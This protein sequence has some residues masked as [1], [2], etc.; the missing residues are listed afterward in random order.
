MSM[1]RNQLINRIAVTLQHSLSTWHHI[2]SKNYCLLDAVAVASL[3]DAST[4]IVGPGWILLIS[5]FF[6]LSI[7]CWAAGLFNRDRYWNHTPPF[8][9]GVK[10]YC[11]TSFSIWK[12]YDQIQLAKS[13]WWKHRIP[14]L[15]TRKGQIVYGSPLCHWRLFAERN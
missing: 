9:G 4:T 11:K 2:F 15:S 5:L 10:R 8:L 13:N 7:S 3:L 6:S 12:P 1:K 14:F